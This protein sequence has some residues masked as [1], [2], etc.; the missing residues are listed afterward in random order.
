MEEREEP[1]TEECI[2]CG[3]KYS[4]WSGAPEICWVC[5]APTGEKIENGI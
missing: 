5:G 4:L 2:N 1:K 3:T